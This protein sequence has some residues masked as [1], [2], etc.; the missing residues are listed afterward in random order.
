MLRFEPFRA[1]IGVRHDSGRSLH[2]QAPVFHHRGP[3]RDR[4]VHVAIEAEVADRAAIDPALDRLQLVDDLHGAHLRRPGH[5]ARGEACLE[6]IDRIEPGRE[7][8]L[9]IRD[10]VHDVR[11][12]LDHHALGNLDGP[13]RRDPADVVAPEVDQ[14]HVLGALL[15]IGE[16]L[17]RRSP[18]PLRSR[19]AGRPAIGRRV[20]VPPA[21]RTRISGDAPTTW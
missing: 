19:A 14:H 5:R 8:T 10:D 7:A 20:T 12:A 6:D 13:G 17:L 1:R 4:H 2:V 16:Q 15:G 21:S 3:D 9:D 11:V 18:R